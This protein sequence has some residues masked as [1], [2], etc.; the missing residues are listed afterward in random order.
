MKHEEQF[1]QTQFIHWLDANGLL[2]TA[3][4]AGVN[5]HP[6]VA[7][8]RKIMGCKAGTPD[9]AIYEPRGKYFGLFIELKAKGGDIDNPKQL[10]WQQELNR[11]GY[12]SII[13]PNSLNLFE[14]LNWLKAQVNNYMKGV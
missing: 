1:L 2:F 3:S 11:R 8:L 13:M 9:I 6:A 10:Y 4:M 12:L 7:R 5:L 14:G